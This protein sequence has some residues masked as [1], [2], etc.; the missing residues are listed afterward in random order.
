MLVFNRFYLLGSLLISFFIP[1][2]TFTIKVPA[3]EIPVTENYVVDGEMPVATAVQTVPT[4]EYLP[5]VAISIAL[6]ISLLLLLRFILNILKINKKISRSEH[7]SLQGATIVLL[8]QEVEPHSFFNN[9]FLTKKEY[10]DG[11]IDQQV[12]VHELTHIR[13]KHSWDVLF[14]ELLQIIIWFNPML[15]LYKRSIKINHEFLADDAVVQ[16]TNNS[17]NYQQ[18]LLKCVYVNNHIP[19]ASSF[20]SSQKND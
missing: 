7:V 16:T 1:L 18:L 6:L 4:T 13:Q 10:E 8:Q 14:I 20:I 19:L 12:L 5:Y 2:I 3:I 9:I 17:L 15:Y 11:R